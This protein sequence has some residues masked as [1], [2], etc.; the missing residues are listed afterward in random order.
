M[1]VRKV[2]LGLIATATLAVACGAAGADDG[3]AKTGSG[4]RSAESAAIQA[5]LA[6][7]PRGDLET[8]A[9]IYKASN[10]PAT[11]IVSAMIL[12][13]MH[14][15]LDASTTDAQTCEDTLIE[16][17]P[18]IALLC[19][20]FASGNL[21]LAG[22]Y[23]EANAKE[24]QIVERF[25]GHHVDKDLANMKAFLETDGK[26]PPL[27]IDVPAQSTTIPLVYDEHDLRP[28]AKA[29]ANGHELTLLVDTGANNMTLSESRAKELGVE[30]TGTASFSGML[31][32]NEAGK[33][34]ILKE[35]KVG[36]IVWHNVPV[37][38]TPEE[39][40]LMGANLLAPLGV[41]R[42][43]KDK[44]VVGDDALTGTTCDTPMLTGSNPW[45]TNIRLMP[46]LQIEG[47]WSTVML[48]S[49]AGMYLLG[50]AKALELATAMHR[51]TMNLGDIGG[52]HHASTMTAK[53]HVVIS[54]QPI[55][56]YFETL[57]DS[58]LPWPIL[59]GGSALRDMDFLLDFKHQ[60]LCFPL[61]AN[62]H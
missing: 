6:T 40:A 32:K 24:A 50:T 11:H 7:L 17:Q 45:G 38:I 43:S 10:D 3:S 15:R 1:A 30:A 2:F 61:H 22:R 28:H 41:V 56:I 25:Q 54:G 8:V 36:S 18:H 46:A 12:E 48:D 53:V 13:R 44:L 26:E 60:H 51:Q 27:E 29:E 37:L 62:L 55:D 20:Q 35:L 21:R 49:G 5:L 19:G 42:I 57:T 34:G 31:T 4:N 59:L 47:Q 23:K 39:H 16:T 9:N 58:S 33:R 14:Y 52:T